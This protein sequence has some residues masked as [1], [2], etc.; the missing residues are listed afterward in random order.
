MATAIRCRE[1]LWHGGRPK[2]AAG[3]GAFAGLTKQSTFFEEFGVGEREE[4]KQKD[5]PTADGA[6]EG[7]L[8]RRGH[9]RKGELMSDQPITFRLGLKRG[10][11]RGAIVQFK[12][13]LTSRSGPGPTLPSDGFRRRQH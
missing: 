13:A 11:T 9:R 6:S 7:R 12:W 1:S 2:D 10:R 4:V 3:P 8:S 5:H